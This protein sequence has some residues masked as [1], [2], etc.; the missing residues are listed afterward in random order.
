VKEILKSVNIL[1]S[2]K[3]E[4]GCLVHFVRLTIT[5]LKDEESARDNHVLGRNFAEYSPILFFVVDV[6]VSRGSVATY[7]KCSGIFND[8]SVANL[9]RN[10]PVKKISPCLYGACAFSALTLL[11]GWQEGHP[12]CKKTERW[13][14]G[15]V[16]LSGARC[17]L[18]YGPDDATATHCLLLQKNPDWFYLS[19][20][21]P[22]G[23]SRKRA[24]KLRVCVFGACEQVRWRAATN[25]RRAP[26]TSTRR[27]SYDAVAT[28]A[29]S[30]E[31]TR[32][33]PPSSG[34]D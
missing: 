11:V 32:S 28:P 9:P 26:T 14:D 3:Q 2:Y 6:I 27:Q 17:R 29:L 10:L 12:A 13:G 30:W 18:A 4:R 33:T 16:Y 25:H 15:V 34:M 1:Q 8:H 7:A 5:L 20:T 24:L 19:G 31:T 21:D 23:Y 22:P